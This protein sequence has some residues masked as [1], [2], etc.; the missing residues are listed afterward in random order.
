M[1]EIFQNGLDFQR[2]V[3]SY[4]LLLSEN[5]IFMKERTLMRLAECCYRVDQIGQG[6]KYLEQLEIE[7][8]PRRVYTIC[9]LKGKY[10]DL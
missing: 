6:L 3:Q 7:I 5:Q 4:S 9:L 1:A 2:A 8:R 10:K